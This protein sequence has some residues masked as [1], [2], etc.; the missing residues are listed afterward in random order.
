M[1]NPVATKLD[2]YEAANISNAKMDI[3][4]EFVSMLREQ[5]DNDDIADPVQASKGVKIKKIGANIIL[6]F[7][8]EG[9]SIR[10]EDLEKSVMQDFSS[11]T[12]MFD[13]ALEKSG[14]SK[15]PA[16]EVKSNV[17]G[18]L[19][20]DSEHPDKDEIEK[21]L[22]EVPNIRDTYMRMSSNS[23]LLAA[24]KRAVEFDKAYEVDPESAM[25]KYSYL[26]DGSS[27]CDIF[28][29]FVSDE[30]YK[31]NLISYNKNEPLKVFDDILHGDDKVE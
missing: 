3:N 15:D 8:V 22:N 19:Y 2:A 16:F 24:G 12:A 30:E 6:G 7:D 25:Q 17:A 5:F 23:S 20:I 1:I 21:I 14:I 9:D 10:I 13:I 11:F 29:I 27:P 31:P 18:E 4:D 26:F 28:S